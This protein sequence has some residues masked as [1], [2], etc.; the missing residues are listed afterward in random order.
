MSTI[1][2]PRDPA[3]A[4][5]AFDERAAP[6]PPTAIPTAAT[7]VK[8]VAATSVRVLKRAVLRLE[9][10]IKISSVWSCLGMAASA[11]FRLASCSTPSRNGADD[12]RDWAECQFFRPLRRLVAAK[13][14]GLGGGERRRLPAVGLQRLLPQADDRDDRG[15]QRKRGADDEREV[16]ARVERSRRALGAVQ[17]R[18]APRGQ[19]GE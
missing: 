15:H 4:A 2:G 6:A 18:G 7:R 12:C 11:A 5:L 13:L 3:F 10:I 17:A 1:S 9:L 14:V 16:V 8:A 19:A